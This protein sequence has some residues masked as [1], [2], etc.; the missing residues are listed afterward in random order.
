MKVPNQET[1]QKYYNAHLAQ[2]TI[3]EQI[4]ARHILLRKKADALNILR[5]L[6]Q[7]KADFSTLAA[8][9]SIDDSNKSRGGDLNWFPR[10]VMVPSF[11]KVAFALKHNGDISQPVQTQYGWHI[12]QRLEKRPAYRQTLAEAKDEIIQIL[13]KKELDS[14]VDK[15]VQESQVKVIETLN[16]AL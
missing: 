15:L 6:K 12:I 10:G 14:W 8:Q 11:E 1:I 2:F 16:P 4:H 9:Y 5:Q 7:H 13:Q 3:P